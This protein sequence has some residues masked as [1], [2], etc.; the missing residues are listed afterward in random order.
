MLLLDYLLHT[1][2]GDLLYYF[3]TLYQLQK[4]CSSGF[5]MTVWLLTVLW[6]GWLIALFYAAASTELIA[7]CGLEGQRYS[8]LYARHEGAW[9]SGSITSLILKLGTSWS[10]GVIVT[11]NIWL[12]YDSV[13]TEVII[14][15][16]LEGLLKFCLQAPYQLLSLGLCRSCIVKRLNCEVKFTWNE[17]AVTHNK[18][19]YQK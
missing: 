5:H 13:S 6:H 1:E 16:E 17:A 15:C 18:L 9:R 14:D 12:F 11:P 2:K 4:I 3:T 10:W 7:D 19:Q 8:C